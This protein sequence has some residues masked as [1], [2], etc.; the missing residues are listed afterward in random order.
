MVTEQRS[1]QRSMGWLRRPGLWFLATI[2]LFITFVQYSGEIHH[3]SFFADLNENLGLTRFTVERILYLLPIIWASLMFGFRGGAI[4]ATAALVCMLPRAVF[5]SD[6]PED[7]IVETVAVFCVG[8]LTAYSLESLRKERERRAELEAAQKQL[9]SHLRVI[10]QSEKRLAA[11]NRTSD[12][13]SQSLEL[14]LVLQSAMASVADVMGVEVVRIYVR[15]E[16]A[17]VLNL[18]AYRGVSD[19]FV[20]GVRTIKVGEGFNGRVAETGEPMYVEDASEDPRLTRLVVKQENIRSQI[21]VPMTAKGK[22][23]GTLAAAMHSYRKFLPAEV[24]LIT[25]IA[26]QIGVAVDNARLYQ[27]Q[28][29]V[30]EELRVSEQRYRGLFENA[31]DAIWLHD[32]EDRI[33]AAN[34]ACVR[35]TGYGLDELRSLR[36]EKLISEDTVGIARKI[37]QRLLA[38]QALGSL[39]EVKLIKRDGSEAIAQLAC[40]VVS[41]DGRPV[42][43]QNI[44]RDVTEE[45][46]MQENLRFL[47]RQISRAQEEERKRIAQE[48]H[49]DTVQ[50]LVVHARQIDDL[51]SR[52]DRLPKESVGKTLE[53]LY[54]EANSI[55]QG[56]QRMSQDL[57]PATLDRLGLLPAIDWLASRTSKYSGVE[58]KIEVV[59]EE[60]RLPDEA[61]LVLFR[62]TQEAL[63]NVWKH[64]GATTTQVTVEFQEKMTRVTI[65]DN[66]K[67]FEP[68]RMVGDLPRYGKLGLAGMQERAELL[69]GTL[70]IT[71]ELDKGT[72]VVA[73]LPV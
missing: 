44:A 54:E 63:R 16:K 25:A 51:T 43:F 56:V 40:S 31:H 67:G 21:I 59:G 57:R 49:D 65:K 36:A 42:A 34:D 69:A 2:F 70:T 8:S 73:E 32:L 58:V 47:V 55:M 23:V 28:K 27:E 22:V 26:N 66:G 71:S 13:V 53:R 18:A 30:A 3:P 68:P 14:D 38:G 64:A 12:V 11:L 61:E 62:I 1:A 29:L 19:E 20:S 46:R 7:A 4:T 60:R 33:I 6:V 72:T 5:I 10:E 24:E 9:E 48:L 41:G 15:D 17:G 37:E 45:R 35:L 39:G 52:L 50:A